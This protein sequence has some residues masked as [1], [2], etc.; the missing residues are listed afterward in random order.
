MRSGSWPTRYGSHDAIT[1]SL[2][3]GNPQ[4]PASPRPTSP[5]S[6]WIWTNSQRSTRRRSTRSMRTAYPTSRRLLLRPQD[7]LVELS[8]DLLLEAIDRLLVGD[9]PAPELLHPRPDLRLGGVVAVADVRRQEVAVRQQPRRPLGQLRVVLVAHDD[10]VEH[11]LV[12]RS[13]GVVRDAGEPRL[14]WLALWPEDGQQPVGGLLR[15]R[16]AREDEA[17]AL[18][19]EGARLVGLLGL[20]R[21]RAGHLV[22]A[23][24]LLGVADPLVGVDAGEDLALLPEGRV[25]GERVLGEQAVLEPAVVHV[26]D[27]EE[28]GRVEAEEPFLVEEVVAPGRERRRQRPVELGPHEERRD[29]LRPECLLRLGEQ[30]RE[31]VP[32]LGH[33]LDADLLGVVGAV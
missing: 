2:A 17:V 27:L 16:R 5:L 1:A 25:A 13:A 22:E 30:L 32:G 14:G 28:L 4:K 23:P 12:D 26:D 3:S 8:L 7:R 15:V 10:L 24:D 9:L 20:G 6:V 29:A 31:V 21:D 33:L 19:D 11:R 18:A